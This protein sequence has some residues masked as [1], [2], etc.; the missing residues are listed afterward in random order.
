MSSCQKRRQSERDPCKGQCNSGPAGREWPGDRKPDAQSNSPLR[1]IA[2]STQ[3]IN[4]FIRS[5]AQECGSHASGIIL[6]GAGTDGAAG[7]DAMRGAGG[8]TFAQNPAT[9][10][11][12]KHATRGI[13]RYRLAS[14]SV[15]D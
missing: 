1:D 11:I 6:S 2:W 4:H 7:L 5:L 13:L 3:P 8:V 15:L 10:K 9:E 14:G 12:R